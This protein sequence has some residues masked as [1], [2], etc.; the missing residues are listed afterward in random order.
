MTAVH[1]DAPAIFGNYMINEAEDKMQFTKLRP[2]EPFDGKTPVTFLIPGTSSQYV[3]LKDTM[4]YVECHIEET[5]R[6]GQPL[7]KKSRKRRSTP[8]G[9]GAEEYDSDEG[10]SVAKK[11]SLENQGIL[12]NVEIADLL[13]EAQTRWSQAQE[14]WKKSKAV[15]ESDPD[16]ERLH[17]TA[18]GMEDLSLL[19]MRRYLKAKK[20]HRDIEGLSG[21]IVPVD[22]V[23]HSMWNGVD[24]FMNGEQVSTTN[25]KYMY[26]SYIET[27]LNNSATTKKYQLQNQ[28][29]FGDNGNKDQFFNI[30]FNKGM[31]QRYMKFRDGKKVE[32]MGHLLSDVM[33]IQAAIVNGVEITIQLKPNL[34]NIRLQCFGDAH[35]GRLVIDTIRLYV[36]KIQMTKE[37]MLAHAD[38][39]RE[40]EAV[41]PYK[42]NEVKAYNANK[43]QTEIVIE[44]PYESKIPTRFIVGMI[45]SDAYIGQKNKNPLYFKHYNISRAAFTIN[46][47]SIAKPPYNLDPLKGKFLEPL[48][49]LHSILGKSGEDIDIG[50]TAEDYMDGLF[51]L[52]FDVSPTSASNMEYLAIKEGGNCRLELQFR[53]PLPN[54]IDV[55]TYAIFPW[56]V[57][58]NELRSCRIVPA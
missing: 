36:C 41:Y 40:H 34:D 55:L 56:E 32:L 16:H 28:G 45:D 15:D 27:V 12:T 22:N 37:V 38:L 4:L 44:N 19:S 33:G 24:V 46:D 5:D 54:N 1:T 29:Y 21:A 3:S 49:E 42:K 30:S 23:L 47:E 6:F 10:H 7:P 51:L 52:P 50:I 25:Q 35:F 17:T 43:G 31:E 9:G 48:V 13:D 26:K 53:E 39:M 57:R 11:S 20:D 58:I 14:A 8:L 2:I 18:E